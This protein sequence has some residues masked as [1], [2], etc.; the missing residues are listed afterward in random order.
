MTS[1]LQKAIRQGSLE[2]V[3]AA[4]SDGADIDEADIHGYPGLPLRVACFMGDNAIVDALLKSGASIDVANSEGAGAPIRMALR[5]QHL[6]TVRLL[7]KYGAEIPPGIDLALPPEE[8]SKAR[9]VA[10]VR[11][12]GLAVGSRAPAKQGPDTEIREVQVSHEQW[13]A[14]FG[15]AMPATPPSMPH[16]GEA[17]WDMVKSFD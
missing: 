2:A 12:Q 10:A 9:L 16:S 7:L 14:V 8:I 5:G 6:E 1:K 15:K 3:A 17:G 13:S 4:L 11:Q